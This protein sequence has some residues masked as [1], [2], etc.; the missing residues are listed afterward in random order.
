MSDQEED[1]CMDLAAAGHPGFVPFPRILPLAL[2]GCTHVWP[3]CWHWHVIGPRVSAQDRPVVA[4]P[5]THV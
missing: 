2:P 5:A 3:E 1:Q 4:L